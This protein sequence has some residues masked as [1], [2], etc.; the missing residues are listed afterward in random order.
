MC[1]IC[2]NLLVK[3]YPTKVTDAI[4]LRLEGG[5]A[6]ESDADAIAASFD[7]G[8]FIRFR[9]RVDDIDQN[10]RVDFSSNGCGYM[11]ASGEVL[12]NALHGRH[13][14]DLHGLDPDELTAQISKRLGEFPAERRQCRTLAIEALTG[15]FAAY[16]CKRI[17]EFAGEKAL[18][19][20]CFGVSEEKIENLVRHRHLTDVAGVSDACNAGSGCGACRMLIQEIIDTVGRDA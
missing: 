17:E 7:C 13:L 12:A 9:V 8:C 15:A 19:C 6:F 20:T 5:E 14:R 10:I 18:I 3:L 1:R 11:V 16:R 2:Q 4:V